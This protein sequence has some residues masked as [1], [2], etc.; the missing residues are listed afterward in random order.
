MAVFNV[1]VERKGMFNH[2]Y[3]NVLSV[4]I[5]HKAAVKGE[6]DDSSYDRMSDLL[7]RIYIMSPG[8]DHETATFELDGEL[9][10]ECYYEKEKSELH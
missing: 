2:T 10:Y 1:R 3:R 5:F 9:R 7:L 6:V 8:N 4:D